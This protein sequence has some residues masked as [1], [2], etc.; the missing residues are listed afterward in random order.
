[1]DYCTSSSGPGDARPP[2]EA[3]VSYRT[4][5]QT[6][7][8]EGDRLVQACSSLF[9]TEGATTN[10]RGHR[11]VWIWVANT[12]NNQASTSLLF[13]DNS[14]EIHGME[15]SLG[16]ISFQKTGSREER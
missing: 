16:H 9:E 12:T 5:D 13:R 8:T 10:T 7:K 1:M 6:E 3:L 11:T 14:S 2:L 15:A 4:A